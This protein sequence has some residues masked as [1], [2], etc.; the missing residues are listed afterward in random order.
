MEWEFDA[1]NLQSANEVVENY[2]M[3]V[4]QYNNPYVSDFLNLQPRNIYI[5]SSQLS[6]YNQINLR[7]GDS[8]IVKKVPVTAPHAGIVFDN[9]MN[10]MDYLDVSNRTFQQLDFWIR[11]SLGN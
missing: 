1:N 4:Y 9:G 8:T 3:V 5:H 6:S 11:K 10:P 2:Q 7:T